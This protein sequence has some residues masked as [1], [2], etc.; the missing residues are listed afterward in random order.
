MTS[1]VHV[2]AQCDH[3]SLHHF[4]PNISY[5]NKPITDT[6]HLP[7]VLVRLMHTALTVGST[8][9]IGWMIVN[10]QADTLFYFTLGLERTDRIELVPR[11]VV[12]SM[13]ACYL[14]GYDLHTNR[15]H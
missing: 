8:Q 13:I 5:L 11:D 9:V 10:L 14:N 2:A 7:L 1:R 15:C 3:S 4:A 12:V 6:A